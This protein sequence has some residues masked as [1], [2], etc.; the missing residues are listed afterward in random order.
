MAT[1]TRENVGNN[2]IP[3]AAVFRQS[4]HTT[5]SLSLEPQPNLSD[6]HNSQGQTPPNHPFEPTYSERPWSGTANLDDDDLFN[7]LN[8][9]TIM[10]DIN[11][12]DFGIWPTVPNKSNEDPPPRQSIELPSDAGGVSTRLTNVK[13]SA[14]SARPRMSSQTHRP[15]MMIHTAVDKRQVA[16]STSN[17]NRPAA[18]MFSPNLGRLGDL[19]TSKHPPG[20]MQK[21]MHLG[22]VMYDLQGTYSPDEHGSSP[23]TVC[24]NTFPI[25]LAGKVLQAATD[26]LRCLRQF[27]PSDDSSSSSSNTS[28]LRRSGPSLSDLRDTEDR[29]YHR[30]VSQYQ[31]FS[32]TMYRPLSTY[33]S[34]SASSQASTE[35]PSRQ[36]LAATKPTTLQLIANYMGLL[37]LYL[38]LYNGVY[39]YARFTECDFRQSQPIW[40]D[41]TIGDAPLY[42]FADIQ[43][44]LVLQVAARLLEDIE[45]ALGLT[46]NCRVSKKSPVEG[47]GILGMNVTAHFIEM[48]MSE[49]TTGPEP[50][51]STVAR[52][53]NIMYCLMEM[54]DAPISFGKFESG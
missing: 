33:T 13:T 28:P 32:D 37:Q 20:L 46:E 14:R 41:L 19:P 12:S 4:E 36:V 5:S 34:S 11:S 26:F 47:S 30:S 23:L 3:T 38:L 31:G 25:E 27:F 17:S 40:K 7:V 24:S 54:L 15:D 49:V 42:H 22:G 10:G 39:D 44:K 9:D 50:G 52:L 2:Q 29:S 6:K 18:Q 21:L 35:C 8:D 43:I 51:R 1:T 45:A 53:R 16:G 48:C